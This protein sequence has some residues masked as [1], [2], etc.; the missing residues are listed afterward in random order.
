M[1]VIFSDNFCDF[2]LQG[3]LQSMLLH[4]IFIEWLLQS[5]WT[6]WGFPVYSEAWLH[7][8]WY[9]GFG[10]FFLPL[11]L[12]TVITFII[13]INRAANITHVQHCLPKALK[14][15]NIGWEIIIFLF[16]YNY[17]NS[18]YL[19]WKILFQSLETNYWINWELD[20]ITWLQNLRIWSSNE[21]LGS[22]S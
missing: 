5:L 11:H 19:T 16:L 9:L 4:N 21:R 22:F 8:N 2:S 18:M 20:R 15:H 7:H 13:K 10:F 1:N 6:V 17:F 12:G 3:F 14:N